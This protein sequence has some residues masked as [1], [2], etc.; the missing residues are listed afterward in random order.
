MGLPIS[1]SLR[2]D[3]AS[4]RFNGDPLVPR[5]LII[6]DDRAALLALR[7]AF[8]ATGVR[9]T[10]ASLGRQSHLSSKG[11]APDVV[12]LAAGSAA[13]HDWSQLDGWV[14]RSVPVIV[15]LSAPDGARAIAAIRRGADAFFFK[16]LD[17]ARLR[18][19][20]FDALRRSSAPPSATAAQA[21]GQQADGKIVMPDR[22]IG[23]SQ[24]MRTLYKQLALAAL[25]PTAALLVGETGAGKDLAAFSLHRH[26]ARSAGRYERIDVAGVPVERLERELFGHESTSSPGEQRRL[27][28]IERCQGGTLVLNE[29]D[30]LPM[31]AQ[32]RMLTI[33]EQCPLNNSGGS[34]AATSDVRILASTRADL[35]PLVRSGR[36]R[37]E[38]LYYLREF[39]VVVPPLRERADDLPELVDHFLARLSGELGLAP[40]RVAPEALERLT[41]HRWP[42]NLWELQ[43]VL[44]MAIRRCDGRL[45][46]RESLPDELAPRPVVSGT[47]PARPPLTELNTLIRDAL[48]TGGPALYADSVAFFDRF[49]CQRVLDHTA[50]NQSR[51][52]R[53]LG[54]T[55][56]SLRT[57]IKKWSSPARSGKRTAKGK[58][59]AKTR[60]KK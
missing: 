20:V 17:Y 9:I 50:G 45:L 14:T 31:R 21:D 34:Q 52:A 32:A 46:T 42:G 12:I 37:P 25:A 23:R 38:L 7:Q 27:G 2:P 39:V 51:A 54:I 35:E 44:R 40:P 4:H 33:I 59:T 1:A 13:G 5:L 18:E 28:W 22:L 60:S 53:L 15:V 58:S 24:A 41:G 55:R 30:R 47:G 57:K 48:E 49:I 8:R 10:I 56:R 26:S 3:E 11:R 36:F 43:S 29:V 16:P 6:D 19:K